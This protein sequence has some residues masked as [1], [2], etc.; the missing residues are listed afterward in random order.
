[1][2]N[3]MYRDKAL[4]PKP[5]TPNKWQK[6]NSNLG[7]LAVE[8]VSLSLYYTVPYHLLEKSFDQCDFISWNIILFDTV[9]RWEPFHLTFIYFLR[10]LYN[11]FFKKADPDKSRPT[12]GKKDFL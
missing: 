10:N 6:L 7:S 12:T 3:L 4:W 1:M 9:C 5:Y 11:H 8:F 2:N